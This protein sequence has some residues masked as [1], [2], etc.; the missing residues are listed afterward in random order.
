MASEPGSI[1]LRE[2]GE[3]AAAAACCCAALPGGG[4]GGGCEDE[5]LFAAWFED[6]GGG[7]GGGGPPEGGPE[8]EPP[9]RLA[10]VVLPA[11]LRFLP[12]LSFV[13]AS[14]TPCPSFSSVLSSSLEPIERPPGTFG[15]GAGWEGE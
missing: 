13:S 5:L 11:R 8:A 15:G 4:G 6:G 7:G 9:P 10:L 12:P 1:W 2:C 14:G 3:V